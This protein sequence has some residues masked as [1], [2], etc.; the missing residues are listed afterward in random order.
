MI[1]YLKENASCH[2]N[3]PLFAAFVEWYS[4]VAIAEYEQAISR[5]V[6]PDREH[7]TLSR[8]GS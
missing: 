4:G 8:L 5:K 3:V 1:G 6:S 7:S 2:Q